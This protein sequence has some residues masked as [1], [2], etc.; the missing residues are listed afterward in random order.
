MLG[1]LAGYYGLDIFRKIFRK[2]NEVQERAFTKS[3]W[4]PTNSAKKSSGKK[5][6]KT[7]G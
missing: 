6:K 7:N 5:K 2:K 4:N 1:Y 3:P